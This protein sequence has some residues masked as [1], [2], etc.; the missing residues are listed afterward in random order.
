[1]RGFD[2]AGVACTLPHL[3]TMPAHPCGPPGC[4]HAGYRLSDPSP[5]C[6]QR[7]LQAVFLL[8]HVTTHLSAFGHN[9]GSKETP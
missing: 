1:M 4:L 9:Q 3:M 7:A 8:R 6:Q 2:G 5:A